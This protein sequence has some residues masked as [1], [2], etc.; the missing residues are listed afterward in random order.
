MGSCMLLHQ[1]P[2][3]EAAGVCFLIWAKPC[4]HPHV[5]S[6][7]VLP[8]SV[9]PEQLRHSPRARTQA[10]AHYLNLQCQCM[11]T[12][13]SV[14]WT[15]AWDRQRSPPCPRPASPA[16]PHLPESCVCMCVLQVQA[17]WGGS[18]TEA[19]TPLPL[20]E[21]A[22]WGCAVGRKEWSSST[23]RAFS[24]QSSS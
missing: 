23:H 14:S 19:R 1:K 21:G 12:S 15:L 17:C 10:Q 8:P 13:G 18:C 4:Q 7:P 11:C 6:P 5:Q 22:G 24:Q 9:P 3:S 2:P 20:L 16:Q